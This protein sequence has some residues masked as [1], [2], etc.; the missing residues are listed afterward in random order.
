MTNIDEVHTLPEEGEIIIIVTVREVMGHR[1]YK[2]RLTN[3]AI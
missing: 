2:S 3:P 1:A